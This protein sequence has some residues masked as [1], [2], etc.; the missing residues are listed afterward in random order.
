MAH[1]GSI[2]YKPASRFEDNS[3]HAVCR[4]GTARLSMIAF[5]CRG[6]SDRYSSARITSAQQKWGDWQEVSRC[7]DGM[8][9]HGAMLRSEPKQGS[10]DDA[11]GEG[12]P[13]HNIIYP[14][15]QI[16]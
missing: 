1:H 13:V 15:L 10:G 11:A 5:Y 3:M 4:F 2:Y 14:T 8:Y 9:L 6:P 16:L 7:P 12:M